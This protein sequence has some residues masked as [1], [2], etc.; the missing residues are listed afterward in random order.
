ME[1][2]K[3]EPPVTPVPVVPPP[4]VESVPTI[5]SLPIVTPAVAPVPTTPEIKSKV[6]FSPK[7]LLDR[8]K[9]LPRKIKIL[10]GVAVF[11]LV[12]VILLMTT[13]PGRRVRNTLLPSP[14]PVPTETTQLPE[15]FDPS[16]Y[17]D[18]PE[19]K[20][21]E[22]KLSEYDKAMNAVQLREDTLR[23]PTL[24]WNVDFKKN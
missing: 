21:I 13:D 8:I 19:I 22:R 17:A 12:L 10:S 16:P 6:P 2:T 11:L 18:D 14:S 1:P 7:Q 24:D 4:V 5:E 15:I 23:P 9:A 3:P 20:D